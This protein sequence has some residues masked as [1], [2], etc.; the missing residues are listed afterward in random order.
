VYVAPLGSARGYLLFLRERTLNAQPFDP[1]KLQATGD[2]T[3]VAEHVAF[4]SPPAGGQFSASENGTVV[5]APEAAHNKQLTW[6]DRNGNPVGTV[7]LPA[8]IA[9][10][11][12]SPDG[13]M[14]A[15]D[16]LDPEGRGR[17]V[18]LHDLAGGPDPGSRLFAMPRGPG[19]V[20]GRQP[21]CIS[22]KLQSTFCQA[23]NRLRSRTANEAAGVS[24]AHQKMK[25]RTSRPV[26]PSRCSMCRA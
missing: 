6:F 24:G 3:P 16:P 2:P 12:I 20:S 15:L 17:E 19:V 25:A 22:R 13:S 4:V 21:D 10:A 9:S 1:S 5:Y 11:A 23:D 8:D 18:W 7:G 14:I 26:S